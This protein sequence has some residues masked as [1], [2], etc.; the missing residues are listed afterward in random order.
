MG[1][2]QREFGTDGLRQ[3]HSTDRV[4]VP[5]R[6]CNYCDETLHQRWL[7]DRELDVGY[8]FN[9]T[10]VAKCPE[11]KT[12]P[13]H[14]V[15]KYIVDQYLQ[16]YRADLFED[17]PRQALL[18]ASDLKQQQIISPLFT[19]A[20]TT[21]LYGKFSA[22]HVSS[23]AR[24]LKEFPSERF[25]LCEASLLLDY[26]PETADALRSFFRVMK[27]SGLFIFHVAQYRLGEGDFAPVVTG[28]RHETHYPEGVDVPSVKFGRAWLE[29]ALARHHF[30]AVS[31]IIT[32]PFSKEQLTFFVAKRP[33]A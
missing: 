2:S 25:D 31:Y 21:S 4:D 9:D 18:V 32:D 14:R 23:D 11:C 30:E 19:H 6:T 17:N 12:R 8:S 7:G 10:K 28:S 13:R 26:I 22:N 16:E 15:L 20:V 29:R 24:D 27:P 5:R 1:I 3:G 33:P